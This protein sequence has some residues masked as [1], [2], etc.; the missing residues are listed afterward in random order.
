MSLFMQIHIP[1]C[2]LNFQT[3]LSYPFETQNYF[4]RMEMMALILHVLEIRLHP[5][6]LTQVPCAGFS[7]EH[8]TISKNLKNRS[9]NSALDSLVKLKKK[10]KEK[11]KKSDFPHLVLT[12]AVGSYFVWMAFGSL[13]M[14]SVGRCHCDDIQKGGN[15]ESKRI[16]CGLF[17]AVSLYR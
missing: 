8:Q 12:E 15:P 10:K 4:I 6:G 13:V 9:V 7:F 16:I 11:K 3:P 17:S 14:S 2:V 1:H 5:F